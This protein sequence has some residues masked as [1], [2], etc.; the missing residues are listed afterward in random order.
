MTAHAISLLRW[1]NFWVRFSVSCTGFGIACLSYAAL[2]IVPMSRARRRQLFARTMSWL[3]CPP[4]GI[5]VRVIGHEHV[6]AYRPCIYVANHQSQIDY[7]ILARIYQ[8]DTLVLASQIAHW[9]IIGWLYE[10]SGS[11]TVD[12]EQPHRAVAA[13]EA[14]KRALLTQDLSIWFFAEG[15]RGRVPGRIGPFKRGAFR[16]AAVSGCP[17]VPVVVSPLKPDTDLRG[18]RLRS[19]DVF[20]RVLSPMVA[21]GSD[22]NAENALR[23]AV[24][25]RM[26]QVLD[27]D[28]AGAAR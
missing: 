20:V 8:G 25:A 16:L 22:H 24:H 5:R 18:R 6:G 14:A 11:L 10:T 21:D 28:L 13:L 27:D 4:F 19:R 2:L 7:P 26:Q 12:R 1:V 23:D 17:V 9:P 3:C 15:T